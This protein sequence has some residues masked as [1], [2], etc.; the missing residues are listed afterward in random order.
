MKA[1]ILLLAVCGLSIFLVSQSH[2]YSS[3]YGRTHSVRPYFK[4]DGTFVQGHRSGNP[5]SG[6]HCHNDICY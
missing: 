3:G 6:V 4:K 5:G 2:A 1:K